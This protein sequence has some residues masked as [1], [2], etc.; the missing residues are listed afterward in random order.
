MKTIVYTSTLGLVIMVLET[1]LATFNLLK[2]RKIILPVT[3]VGL[4]AIF[5]LNL[6]GWNVNQGFYHNMVLI[7]NYSVAFSGLLIV[8]AIFIL[9][10]SGNFYKNEETKISDYLSIT[11]FTLCGALAMVSFGNMAM[12]FLGLEVMSI[13]LYILAGSKRKDVRSNEAA[14][15]YFLMGSFA[16]G[17][18]LFGIA[19]VY[20][21]TG[22]FDIQKIADFVAGGTPSLLYYIGAGMILVAL[23]FK[24]S[25]VPF[26]FWA[27]DV[28]EGSPTVITAL[29]STIVKTAAFAA[30]MRL[31][32]VTFGGVN[33]TW[34]MILAVIIALSLVISNVTAATQQSVKRMLAYSSISHAGFMLMAILANQR[35]GGSVSAILYYSLAYSIGSI[36]AFTVLYN[37]SKQ[38]G[39]TGIEAFNGLGKRNPLMAACMVV[40]MLSLA[41]I[42]VTAGFFAKY[43]VF[44]VLIGTSFKWLIILAI[45]TSAVGVYYYF[46]VIIAM[47]FKST[48]HEESVPMETSHVLLLVITTLFTIALGLVPNYII[49]I[50]S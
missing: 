30:F 37:V 6:L 39:N 27:P 28:Y 5:C 7:D 32:M 24:V 11:I 46:K 9:I 2:W 41:G 40:A 49:E 21:E 50:F 14:M 26:H 10:L 48:E 44:S 3:V 22:S 18:L 17:V 12:F 45:L 4:I 16:S 29:M 31:F 23:L 43:F 1:L 8:L 25:A 35:G 36:S 13:S 33:E 42:P 47:Y 20:G 15:K 34:N 38:N 19:L